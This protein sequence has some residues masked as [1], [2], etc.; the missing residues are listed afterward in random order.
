[1]LKNDS[2]NLINFKELVLY[3]GKSQGNIKQLIEN[4]KLIKYDSSNNPLEEPL[5]QRGFFNKKEVEKLFD[6]TIDSSA[7]KKKKTFKKEEKHSFTE[8]IEID[9][10]HLESFYDIKNN[11]VDVGINIV[12]FDITDFGAFKYSDKFKN[13]IDD[14]IKFVNHYFNILKKHGILLVIGTMN[15]LPYIAV[16]AKKMGFIFRDLITVKVFDL[17]SDNQYNPVSIGV[18]LLLKRNKNFTINKL[19]D[20]HRNCKV[21]EK[22]LKDWGGKKALMNPYGSVITDVWKY[23]IQDANKL[24]SDKYLSYTVPNIL[25]ERLKDLTAFEEYNCVIAPINGV[26]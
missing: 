6:I 20:P 24:I 12:K 19:L 13:R 21:C 15:I 22:P 25:L 2:K 3:T 17:I 4:G 10:Q 16:E 8:V 11:S 5:R 1:M 23:L 18:L 14:N 7:E 9:D 26:Y